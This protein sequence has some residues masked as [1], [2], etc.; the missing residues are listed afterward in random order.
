MNWP[1]LLLVGKR[2]LSRIRNRYL[3]RLGAR[4]ILAVTE[5]GATH[6]PGVPVSGEI[7]V[8]GA[9]DSVMAGLVASL[10]AGATTAEAAFIG[11]MAASITIQQLGTTGTASREQLRQRLKIVDS[12]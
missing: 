11:N 7:D 8:V 2:C 1:W 4:G 12:G 3:S 5:A 9:G 6:V 10:C